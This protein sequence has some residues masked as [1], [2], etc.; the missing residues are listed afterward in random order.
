MDMRHVEDSVLETMCNELPKRLK[1]L[2]GDQRLELRQTWQADAVKFDV[3]AIGH[4]RDE[5]TELFGADKIT[6]I[7]SG[8]GHDSANTA[9][10]FPT[11]M[12]FVP[13]R[14]G[15]SHNPAEFT[16]QEQWYDWLYHPSLIDLT[17]PTERPRYLAQ[18]FD[19]TRLCVQS[20]ATRGK[21]WSDI[22]NNLHVEERRGREGT[23]PIG[24]MR[25]T[26]L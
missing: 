23:N 11:A 5:A 10:H 3:D 13:C 9:L 21:R 7:T 15:I 1:A 4:V 20:T 18:F 12:V 19:S 16:N 25:E 22:S 2:A 24:G 17:V 8:A 14:G 26:R 6:D